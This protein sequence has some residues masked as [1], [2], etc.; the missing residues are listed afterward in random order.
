[1]AKKLT[2]LQYFTQHI[3]INKQ[4]GETQRYEDKRTG[5]TFSSREQVNKHCRKQTQDFESE[6]DT[7]L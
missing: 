6:A 2:P 3:W 1:M 5:D 7:D 4:N